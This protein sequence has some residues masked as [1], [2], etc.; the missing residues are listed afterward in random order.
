MHVI[1]L[2]HYLSFLMYLFRNTSY[3]KKFWLEKAGFPSLIWIWEL[4]LDVSTQNFIWDF[5]TLFSKNMDI[6]RL[7][8][9]IQALMIQADLS[10]A[11]SGELQ[12][13]LIV[14]SSIEMG[15]NVQ[16]WKSP[17][18]G[19]TVALKSVASDVTISNYSDVN[20]QYASISK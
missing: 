6:K 10:M 15:T 11:F 2:L 4:I 19:L 8:S 16:S 12:R 7:F 20:L 17:D 3:G 13:Y 9:I 18:I 1:D 14:L 5:T